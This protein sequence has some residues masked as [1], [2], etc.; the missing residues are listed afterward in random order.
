MIDEL[1]LNQSDELIKWQ[2]RLEERVLAPLH[3]TSWRY[4]AWLTFLLAVVGWAL[5][6][7]SR[8]LENGLIVTNMRDRISWGVYIISFVFFI[9]ISHA[10]T[11][12]SAILRV[13]RARWQMSIT[14][15]AEFITGVALMVAALYPFIDMGRPDRILN[16]VFFGRWQSPLMWDIMAIITYFTGS[17]IY[18][19]LPLIPDF[20]LL[21]DRLGAEAPAWKRSLF[22]TAALGWK[23]TPDQRQALNRAMSVMMIVIIP[24]AVSVH[25]VVSWVFAMTLRASLDSTL[26]G[27]FF[28]AGAIY[29]GIAAIII[30]MAVLRRLMHLEEWITRTQF[31]YLGYLLAALAAI[32]AY[33]NVSEFLTTGYKMA[34]GIQFYIQELTVGPFAGL[35]WF[36]ILGGILLPILLM[37]HPRTRTIK[38]IITAAVLVIV[39]MWVERYLLIVAGFR[40]PLMAYPPSNYSPSWTEW[41]ILAGGVALFM[42]IITIF[43]K[44][45]PVVSIWEVI[46]HRGPEPAERSSALK[47]LRP[48]W[49]TAQMAKLESAA[50]AGQPPAASMTR[51]KALKVM[52]VTGLSAVFAPAIFSQLGKQLSST[53]TGQANPAPDQR[54]RRWA[55][56]IDLRYCDG[57]QSVGKPPQ[58]TEACIQGHFVP[59]P[60][61]WIQVYEPQLPG[62]GT[63]FVPTPCQ[64]CQNAPCVNVCPVGATFTTPE[65]V[66]LI[67]Q[68]RCIGCRL[69]MEA[70]QYDRRFFNWGQPPIPP[71]ATLT[72]YDTEHQSPAQ[73]GTVMKCDFCPD[74]AR[75]GRLPYCAQGCPN[76]AIYYGDLE[77][78]LATNGSE[79]VKLSRILSEDSTYRL[80]ENLGTMPRVYYISGHGELVG[81]DAYQTGRLPTQ[82]PWQE[83]LKGSRTWIR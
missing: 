33:M 53:S 20:A 3:G 17:L 15:M 51:R 39:A 81:R 59:A 77:E 14:R 83:Q 1:K 30:L 65:G 28:V 31:L 42:L 43:A 50:P 24:V 63:Q 76:H 74:M 82:W 36:Y 75:A 54:V 27:I 21:R 47:D 9:G 35:F 55:M 78:D 13:T 68:N 11:L 22:T 52:G 73:K 58:C 32:M 6:A 71:E 26:F 57:C 37:I 49:G 16:M 34:E 12:L 48:A 10:G 66:V 70:C 64:Q 45:F 18:L 61:E 5:Y 41:S 19:Y 46:E 44:L 25:T 4:Y 67:D 69:C 38:G 79:V 23:G 80:K 7:Y 8:Q 60:M 29:S 40:V 72:E 2:A 62:G 56:V